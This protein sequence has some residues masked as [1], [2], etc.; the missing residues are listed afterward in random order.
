MNNCRRAAKEFDVAVTGDPRSSAPATNGP[1]SHRV[2]VPFPAGSHPDAIAR[3]LIRQSLTSFESAL[4][5]ENHPDAEGSLGALKPA[6]SI[7]SGDVLLCTVSGPFLGPYVTPSAFVLVVDSSLPV[8]TLQEFV[9]L[10]KLKPGAINYGSVGNGSAAHRA[11]EQL[12]AMAGIVLQH[13]PH[14]GLTHV[15]AAILDGHVQAALISPVAATPFVQE[16]RMRVVAATTAGRTALSSVQDIV[17]ASL[18][19]HLD[20]TMMYSSNS[21]NLKWGLASLEQPA[22][23]I[24]NAVVA[25]SD[26]QKDIFRREKNFGERR[27]IEHGVNPIIVASYLCFHEI[28]EPAHAPSGQVNH[29][30]G[31]Q[32]QLRTMKSAPSFASIEIETNNLPYLL[33]NSS[34]ALRSAPLQSDLIRNDIFRRAYQEKRRGE[35]KSPPQLYHR[36]WLPFDDDYWKREDKLY[37]KQRI[38]ILF[39]IILAMKTAQAITFDDIYDKYISWI[40]NNKPYNAAEEELIDVKKLADTYRKLFARP[41]PPQFRIFSILSAGDIRSILALSLFLVAEAQLSGDRLQ[42]ALTTLESYLIRRAVCGLPACGYD[43]FFAKV[44][45]VLRRAD[46]VVATLAEQLQDAKTP[47]TLWPDDAMFGSAWLSRPLYSHLSAALL[48]YVLTCVERGNADDGDQACIHP[49]M[50]VQHI[51]PPAWWKHWS[52]QGGRIGKSST[53][54]MLDEIDGCIFDE[55]ATNRDRVVQTIGNLQLVAGPRSSTLQDPPSSGVLVNDRTFDTASLNKGPHKIGVWDEAA[56]DKR[57][58]A[59]FVVARSHWPREG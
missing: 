31:R 47:D 28:F 58:S 49:S 10:A 46:D 24:E 36:Y 3:L 42:K 17:P 55:E 30:D 40:S 23:G 20:Q 51:M 13:Q 45:Q 48:Q 37:K 6:H 59:L 4:A 14:A 27:E 5:I 1:P 53:D 2:I 41:T 25:L 26:P 8:H 43:D 22:A 11:M 7:R 18:S 32:A 19:G 15:T 54:S 50:T 16:G 29:E 57:G 44:L 38:D 33:Q 56:I 35:G 21:E 52:L 12:E 9:A 39:G 34:S